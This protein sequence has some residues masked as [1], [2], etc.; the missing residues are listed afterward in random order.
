[1]KRLG[2]GS[3]VSWFSQDPTAVWQRSVAQSPYFPLLSLMCFSSYDTTPRREQA[4]DYRFCSNSLMGNFPQSLSCQILLPNG[5]NSKAWEFYFALA[6]AGLSLAE[7]ISSLDLSFLFLSMEQNSPPAEDMSSV[8][9][10]EA[11]TGRKGKGGREITTQW[12]ITKPYP[13][14]TWWWVSSSPYVENTQHCHTV[15]D[16]SAWNRTEK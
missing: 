9:R 13:S 5:K 16:L 12:F 6:T 14:S 11:E 4:P 15:V 7:G 10:R 8:E 2:Q 3:E 1:M